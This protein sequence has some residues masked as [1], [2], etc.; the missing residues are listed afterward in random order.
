MNLNLTLDLIGLDLGLEFS[1]AQPM[2][3]DTFGC[4]ERFSGCRETV[5]CRQGCRKRNT[6]REMCRGKV[7][8]FPPSFI[9]YMYF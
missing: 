8:F 7:V 1:D 3:R 2:C 6:S 5:L 9:K 4:R